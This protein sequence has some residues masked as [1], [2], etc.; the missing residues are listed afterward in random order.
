MDIL[1]GRNVN[2]RRLI[3][4]CLIVAI[5]VFAASRLP[6]VSR[7]AAEPASAAPEPAVTAL[8]QSSFPDLS[9][10]SQ[11]FSQW[12][13]QW[14]VVNFWATWCGPCVAEM[15]DLDRVQEKL[16]RGRVQ[17]VGL[18]TE[19]LDKLQRFPQAP[20][21]R[22]PLL[23]GGFDAMGVARALGD[24]QG[25]LPFTV[26]ISPTGTVAHMQT[27]ALKPGQLEQWLSPS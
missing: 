26:L 3:V 22:F 24:A 21:L 25:V 9:G 19:G 18:G 17:I 1:R 12:K 27:G 11:S 2:S 23:A 16:G 4:V 20:H 6:R 15:P 5:C 8:W 7:D 13:G 14:L 10:Q